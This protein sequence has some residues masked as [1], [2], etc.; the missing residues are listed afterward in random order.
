MRV[1]LLRPPQFIFRK[2]FSMNSTPPL[3]LAFIAASVKAAGFKLTVIDAI[4]EAPDQINDIEFSVYSKQKFNPANYATVGLNTEE[5]IRRIPE[6][7]RVIGVSCMFS[8]NWLSDRHILESVGKHFP[9]ALVIAGGES[10]SAKPELWLQQTKELD[11]C[12][13]GEGEET[14]VDLLTT[15]QKGEPLDSVE[16]IVYKVDGETVKTTPRRKR[17]RNIDELPLP[18]WEY[19]PLDNYE[20][21]EVKW[22]VTKRK[23]LPVMATRGCPYE[24]TF[25][26]SPQMWGTRYYMRSPQHVADEIESL[27]QKYGV[28]NFDFFDLTAIIN[29]RWIIEFADEVQKRNLDITWQLPAGT[30][31]EAIDEQVAKALRLSGC[32]DVTYAPESGSERM[33]DLVKKKVSLRKMLKSMSYANKEGLHI[34]INMI[35]G[36]PDEK[37]SDV[38]KTAWFMIRCSWVG[39]HELGTAKFHP[40]PGSVLFERLVK[41]GKIDL[42]TDDFFLNAISIA[43]WK[44]SDYYNNNIKDIYYRF[45]FPLMY[46]TFYFTNFLF[47]PSR[48]WDILKN[49][50][51]MDYSTRSE[52]ALI[53]MLHRKFGLKQDTK[54]AQSHL[55]NQS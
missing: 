22:S 43:A 7:V 15:I 42:S 3:G 50:V 52:R 27:Q 8:N 26:S 29:K 14:I 4:G 10:I 47:R 36:L 53:K 25:C 11:V 24:C 18:A 54:L 1:V 32:T 39:V 12:V 37:H 20:K 19:F 48:L 17:V 49:I 9:K 34:F 23:S 41:E 13:I 44:R 55:I 35:L 33:L 28:G 38:W 2:A 51:K 40:Y 6:D 16:S 30:R 31:S 5:I 45:Y 46:L 21:H